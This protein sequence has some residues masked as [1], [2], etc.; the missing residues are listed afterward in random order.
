MGA[1]GLEAVTLTVLVTDD[2]SRLFA[3]QRLNARHAGLLERRQDLE[4]Q[5][6]TMQ[7]CGES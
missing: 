1:E 3:L 2:A 7:V 6:S 4:V 5:G